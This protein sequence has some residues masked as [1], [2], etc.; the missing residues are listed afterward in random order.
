[1]YIIYGLAILVLI[2]IACTC[3]FI[4]CFVAFII[5]D[6]KRTTKK[7]LGERRNYKH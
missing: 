1:M 6:F 7:I 5:K 4:T 3:A 2:I